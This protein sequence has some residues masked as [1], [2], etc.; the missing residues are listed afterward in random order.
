MVVMMEAIYLRQ[1]GC[2]TQKRTS[3]YMESNCKVF[4]VFELIF[5]R[6]PSEAIASIRQ[7]YV[8]AGM[9]KGALLALLVPFF[10]KKADYLTS[11]L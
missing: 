2:T 6:S 11:V 3:A 5:I 1:P 10:D 9:K 7:S 8:L 4:A